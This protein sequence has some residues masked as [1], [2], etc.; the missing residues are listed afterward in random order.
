MVCIYVP[1]PVCRDRRHSRNFE[2]YAFIFLRA[3]K[4]KYVWHVGRILDYRT[5]IERIYIY[6]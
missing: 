5:Y 1:P 6:I 2:R 4:Y 3:S